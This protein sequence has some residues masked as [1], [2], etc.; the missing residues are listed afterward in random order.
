MATN[1]ISR[2]SVT[3]TEPSYSGSV[4]KCVINGKAIYSDTKCGNG[5]SATRL[6]LPDSA[7]FVS[8]PKERLE[9]LVARRIASEREYER[10][11]QMQIVA[12]PLQTI[13]MECDALSKHINWIEGMARQPQTGQM[14]GWLKDEKARAQSRK[15][16]LR[17]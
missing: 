12:T 13:K 5:S 3:Y 14:Q 7:G 17:C 11:I 6:I 8:P 4:F 9:D 1:V 10:S 15:F 16:E 2:E